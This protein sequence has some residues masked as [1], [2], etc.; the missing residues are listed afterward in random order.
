MHPNAIGN[1]TRCI[2]EFCRE[3]QIGDAVVT[4]DPDQRLYHIG[5]VRSGAEYDATGGIWVDPAT[6]FEY[7]VLRYVRT[8]NWGPTVSR[9]QLS[10]ASQR[11]LG[12]PPTHFQLPA[13]VRDELRRL[14][15]WSGGY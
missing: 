7:E 5:V 12:R 10:P 9:D 11:Y 3:V 8:V 13:E 14:C 15:G 1:A 6:L 4:Y 2:W